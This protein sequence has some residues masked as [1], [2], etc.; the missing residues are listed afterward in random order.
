M[1]P[2]GTL[3]ARLALV[4]A[5]APPVESLLWPPGHSGGTG[6]PGQD[7]GTLME[8]KQEARG[9]GG[10]QSPR[11]SLGSCAREGRAGCS[12]DQGFT[13]CQASRLVCRVR[14]WAL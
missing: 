1:V 4:L 11:F 12:G 14:L 9:S 6:A 8:K 13:V 2:P 7:L 10:L 3:G 5:A